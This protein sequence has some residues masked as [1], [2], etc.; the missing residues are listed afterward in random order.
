[1]M[2]GIEDV[3]TRGHWH[4]SVLD[5]KGQPVGDDLQLFGNST[6]I[7]TGQESVLVLLNNSTTLGIRGGL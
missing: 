3:G 7:Y 6:S 1:M 5:L 2:N 4:L